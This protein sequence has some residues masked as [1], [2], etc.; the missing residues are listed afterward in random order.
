MSARAQQPG[1]A[2]TEGTGLFDGVSAPGPVRGLDPTQPF[3]DVRPSSLNQG[4]PQVGPGRSLP[5]IEEGATPGP[6]GGTAQPG[7]NPGVSATDGGAASRSGCDRGPEDRHGFF[8]RLLDAYFGE[9]ETADGEPPPRRAPPAPFSSPPF[10]FAEFPGPTIGSPST[11]VAQLQPP[12]GGYPLMSAILGGPAGDFFRRSNINVYG[13]VD[14]SYNASTSRLSNVPLAYYI[15]PNHLELSQAILIFERLPDTVQTDHCDWGFKWTN[16]YGMDFRYTT[17]KGWFSDQLLKHN[18]LYGYDALQLYLDVYVPQIGQGT[19]FRLGRFISPI[20]IEAQLT[21]D[22]Y[23]Y[24]HSIMYT[25]DPYTFTGFQ[26]MTKL[27]DRWTIQL[28]VHAGNDMAPWTTSSQPNGMFLV[29]W[30]SEGNNDSFYGGV[31]SIGH[32]YFKNGHDDLQVISALW[33]HKFNDRLHTLTETYY[34]WQR[35]ALMGGT[36][37]NG[38]PEPYFMAVGPGAKLPGLSSSYGAVNFTPYKLTDRDYI[39]LRND[40][41]ADFRGMRTGFETTYFEH[42]LGLVHR[43]TEWCTIRPE[44]RFEYTTGAKAYDNGTKREQFAFA[45]DVIVRF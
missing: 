29:R 41:L 11:V 42:T 4:G 3:R 8:R 13:W 15:V 44:L 40:V 27:S 43:P 2:L 10:P 17:A 22:N 34:I 26:A 25:Y 6:T 35:D 39:V 14:P 24:S 36:V 20:D 28:G 9:K 18:R 31:D 5:P 23:L 38:P 19:I 33:T 12:T 1:P 45:F 21:T 30:V 32:G 7:A 16:L 37:I